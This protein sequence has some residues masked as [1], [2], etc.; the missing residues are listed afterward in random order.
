MTRS[1]QR[2]TTVLTPAAQ[3]LTTLANIK[4]ELS[5]PAADTSNDEWLKLII[6][7]ISGAI[8]AYCNRPFVS[9]IYLDLF[10]N[11]RPDGSVRIQGG[12]DPLALGRMPV[13][14][15]A[16]VFDLTGAYAVPPPAVNGFGPRTTLAASM[17]SG[18]TTLPLSAALGITYPYD[19]LIDTGLNQEVVTVTALPG[20]N[21]YTVTRGAAGTTARAHNAGV[22]ATQALDQTLFEFEPDTGFLTRLDTDGNGN[23]W[24]VR[25]TTGEIAVVYT[26]G[27]L[28]IGATNPNNYPVMPAEL[29]AAV[30]RLA[31]MRFKAKGRDPMLRTEGE[32]GIGQQTFWIGSTPGQSGS[33]PPEIAGL[34]EPYRIIPV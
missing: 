34:V 12:A 13:A 24:P 19:V 27:Y 25:W 5:L 14:A 2:I 1:I 3:V 23:F 6:G 9:Q 15:I 18:Q 17:T 20:G 31:T 8:S 11:R 33:L 26:A 28:A 21:T 7:Q 16:D 30:L 32:P 4:L 22:P 29:E 10:R